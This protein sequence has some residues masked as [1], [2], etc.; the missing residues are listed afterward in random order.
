MKISNNLE[1]WRA[2]VITAETGNVTA[3]S[4]QLNSEISTVS[5]YIHG[6]EHEYGT[7]F[8]RRY[9]PW[10]LTNKGMDLHMR[11]QP[12][13]ERFD[14]LQ[15]LSRHNKRKLRIKISVP[16]SLARNFIASMLVE[17][18]NINPNIEFELQ[19][20]TGIEGLLNETTDISYMAEPPKESGLIVRTSI[21]AQ[22]WVL[23]SRKY[24]ETHPEPMR[25]E[26][27]S[28]HVGILHSMPNH[29]DTSYLMKDGA[30][31]LPLKWKS[32]ISFN[33]QGNIKKLLLRGIGIS[34]DLSP[35]ICLQELKSGEIVPLLKGWRREPWNFCVVTN[36]KKENGNPEFKKFAEWFSKHESKNAG[37]RMKTAEQYIARYWE[38]P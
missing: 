29:P 25:P 16:S 30:A 37:E 11:V 23:A 1:A 10:K 4:I 9:R 31:S 24:L 26:D 35:T 38:D 15:Q 22:A 8:N 19:Q 33:D 34:P 21:S 5:R 14:A 17:Y 2:F 6:L 12:L 7:L 3:S 13:V 36:R 27:L 20:P 32:V 28:E 18:A